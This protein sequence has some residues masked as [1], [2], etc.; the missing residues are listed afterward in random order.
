MAFWNRTDE[1]QLER[2]LRAERPQPSDELVRSLSS[3]IAPARQP[4]RL[5]LP[6]LALVA[7]VTAVLAVSLGTAGALG[8]AGGSVHTFSLSVVHL[9]S[10]PKATVVQSTTKPITGSSQTTSNSKPTGSVR[11]DH[12]FP[13]PDHF[14]FQHQYGHQ[15]SICW[16]GEIIQIPARLL[17]FYLLHGARPPGLCLHWAPYPKP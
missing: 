8:A 12:K 4:R 1:S 9:V 11:P 7:A 17:F 16:H 10:P 14:P 5:T 6:K 2:E 3:R 13:D 15:I